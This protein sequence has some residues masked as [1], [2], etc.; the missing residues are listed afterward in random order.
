MLSSVLFQVVVLVW[1]A[2]G[3][4][5]GLVSAVREVGSPYRGGWVRS[6]GWLWIA[7]SGAVLVYWAAT[8]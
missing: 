2:F 8:P 4:A 3:V 6:I 1:G 7:F 5:A